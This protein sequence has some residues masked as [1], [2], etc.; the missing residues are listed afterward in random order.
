MEKKLKIY[1]SCI[2]HII[3]STRFMTSSLS[4]L[5]NTLFEGIH[6]IKCRY[7]HDDKKCEICVTK[8]KHYDYFLEYMNFKNDLIEYK[9][10]CLHFDTYKFS[11][12]GNNKFIP[13][14]WKGFYP[15]EGLTDAGYA[16]AKRV[17]KDFEMRN[18]REYH[19]L[20]VQSDI[21]LLADVSETLE[22]SALKYTNLILESFFQ[23]QN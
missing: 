19:D 9:C 4:N 18:L 2:L 1:I 23:F 6:K 21:L 8:Y 15:L 22:I 7:G 13:F 3:D 17:C 20:Y 10:L 14:L 12:H 5:V 11:N 16:H